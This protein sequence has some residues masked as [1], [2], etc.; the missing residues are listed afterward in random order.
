MTVSFA[1]QCTVLHRTLQ[2]VAPGPALAG[3]VVRADQMRGR[4]R[5]ERHAK[6]RAAVPAAVLD[7]A[8]TKVAALIEVD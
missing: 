6:F 8:R 2:E 7:E 3:S 1:D 4:S 5:I